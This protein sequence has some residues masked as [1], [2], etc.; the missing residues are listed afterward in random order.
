MQGFL[1]EEAVRIA[2]DVYATGEGVRN[3]MYMYEWQLIIPDT[4]F[5]RNG[6]V[7]RWT[8]AA[9]Y[10]A[11][12]TQY[13]ELQV[14]RETTTGTYVKVGNTSNMEP[15]QTAYLN[16]YE[17]VLDPPLQVLAGDVLGIY[18]PSYRNS[19]IHLSFLRNSDFVNWYITQATSPQDSFMV[20]G[21][22]TN[23]VLPLV[24]VSFEP[25]GELSLHIEGELYIE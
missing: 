5:T 8:F 17:C 3:F 24:T 1:N 25:E 6:S 21:S 11:S 23:N 16:V 15:A 20:A 12:A 10:N 19:R 7:M 4:T 13:P 14:W 18:Q 9:Q 2:A 22:Q